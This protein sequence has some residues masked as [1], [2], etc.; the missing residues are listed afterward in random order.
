[1]KYSP[2]TRARHGV[3]HDIDVNFAGLAGVVPV[4]LGGFLLPHRERVGH[5]RL[6]P[7]AASAAGFPDGRRAAGGRVSSRPATPKPQSLPTTDPSSHDHILNRSQPDIG[8]F[9]QPLTQG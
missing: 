5:P 3:G 8:T 2:C 1:M 6:D 9:R 7:L 4:L